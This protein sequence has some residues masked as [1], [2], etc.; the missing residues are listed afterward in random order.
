VTGLKKIFSI[1]DLKKLLK[2]A[3]LQVVSLE[4][5]ENLACYVIRASKR[6]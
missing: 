1:P 5:D 2:A 4:D 3:D 6:A